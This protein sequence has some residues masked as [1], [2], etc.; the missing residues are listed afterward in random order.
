MR[1]LRLLFAVVP[2]DFGDDEVEEFAGEFRVEIGGFRQR[3]EPVDLRGLARGI[4]RGKVVR[5]LE[6]RPR[7]WCA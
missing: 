4:G 7:P 1:T 5:G 3:F 6:L 2:N